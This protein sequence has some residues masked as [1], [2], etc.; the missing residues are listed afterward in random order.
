MRI[1]LTGAS[2]F[3]GHRSA[4][5]LVS[6][7]HHVVAPLRGTVQSANDRH[8][9]ERLRRLQGKVDIIPE[10]PF[11][12]ARFLDVAKSREFDV[13]CHHAVEVGDHRNSGF[14]ILGSAAKN[15][16]NLRAVLRGDERTRPR[17]RGAC[18]KL[19]RV[20]RRGG[21]PAAGGLFGLRRIQGLDRTS[22]ASPVSRNRM[23]YGKFVIPHPLAH[24]SSRGLAPV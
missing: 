18:R 12:T 10:C 19:F 3:I 1:P 9:C 2:S 22:G 24:S 6:A 7:G 14:D 5:A 23:R 15:T 21:Q 11:G 16:V 20:R 4:E 17:R 8:R 13:L